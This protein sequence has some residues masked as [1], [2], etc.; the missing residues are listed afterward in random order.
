MT[1]NND[2]NNA[3]LYNILSYNSSI[4]SHLS[5]FTHSMYLQNQ[6][7]T[8]IFTEVLKQ[9]SSLLEEIKNDNKN[10]IKIMPIISPIKPPSND[11]QVQTNS[12][13]ASPKNKNT[14]ETVRYKWILHRRTSESYSDNELTNLLKS[15][16]TIEDI[17]DLDNKWVKIKHVL[18]LQKMYFL[19][20]TLRKLNNM[21]GLKD[22]KNNIFKK[23]IYY[24]Q[25]P[26]SGEYLH[27][28]ISG[29]P[30]VGKTE[31]AKIYAEIFV[32]LGIL[33]ND[34]FIE[35]KRDNLVGRYL[36]ETSIKTREL[37][38][39]A[40]GGVLFLDE[41]YSLGNEEKRDSFSK[42]AIDMINQ[43]LSEHKDNLMFIIAGY[44]KELDNCFFAFNPGL[45]RRFHSHYKIDGYMPN[46][47]VDIFKLKINST[48][49]KNT[50]NDA[51]LLK[52]FTDN[53]DKFPYYGGDVE[54]LV[55]ECKFT[56]SL[57][58]FNSN[59]NNKEIILNDLE[60]SLKILENKNKD[61]T[62]PYGMYM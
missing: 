45:K 32:K 17:I 26:H 55:N 12:I 16:N 44:E 48:I 20:P 34:N 41:A 36:G 19:I 24:S 14:K 25:N 49:L 15:I 51:I 62:I 37:L 61:T 18:S 2:S 1:N 35:I 7:S 33:K 52:F 58:V 13:L 54:K 5:Q 57:R 50:I 60:E 6:Q 4:L 47:L 9:N 27:T 38:D 42:E 28:I 22:I 53:K 3:L 30:G 10:T 21:V 8:D 56:Q 40:L 59:I 29:P 31:I 46:E 11:M 43:Y 23:I 39:K